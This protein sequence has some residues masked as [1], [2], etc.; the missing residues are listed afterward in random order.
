L[1][2]IVSHHGSHNWKA[3]EISA[4]MYEK[5]NYSNSVLPLGFNEKR[6]Y[7]LWL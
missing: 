6:N 1:R 2:T 3:S 4:N 5:T 7:L